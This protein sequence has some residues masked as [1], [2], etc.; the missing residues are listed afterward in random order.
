M[1]KTGH[2]L[3]RR[4]GCWHCRSIV[5]GILARLSFWLG[6]LLLAILL[7]FVSIGVLL[8]SC[9]CRRPAWCPPAVSRE[10]LRELE[11]KM[12]KLAGLKGVEVQ[13]VIFKGVEVQ[14]VTTKPT[15]PHPTLPPFLLVHG[16]ASDGILSFIK[17][18]KWAEDNGVHMVLARARTARVADA[19]LVVRCWLIFLDLGTVPVKSCSRA[20]ICSKS[21]AI[22]WTA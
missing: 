4:Q 16:L 5:C 3:D 8:S 7:L 15:N 20:W 21:N 14:V 19:L 6:L 13:V 12:L 1:V 11:T 10:A 18:L 9:C 2:P 17:C 22:C